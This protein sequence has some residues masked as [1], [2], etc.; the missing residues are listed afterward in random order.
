MEIME[1]ILE[2]IPNGQA[3]PISPS[4]SEF[5]STSTSESIAHVSI[6]VI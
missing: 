6:I 3:Q 5:I 1:N 4:A 2:G